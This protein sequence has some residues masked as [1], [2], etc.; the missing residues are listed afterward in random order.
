M[1]RFAT[2]DYVVVDKPGSFRHGERARVL[3]PALHYGGP[4]AG[5]PLPGYVH[6]TFEDGKP[7]Y[8]LAESDL[9]PA[10]ES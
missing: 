1:S 3:G 7:Y 10:P 5:E 9:S 8:T 2:G 4:N 6:V